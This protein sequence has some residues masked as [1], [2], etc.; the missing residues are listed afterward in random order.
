MTQV[1]LSS[2]PGVSSL[3]YSGLPRPGPAKVRYLSRE[4]GRNHKAGTLGPYGEGKGGG[5]PFTRLVS[6]SLCFVFLLLNKTE[7]HA[8]IH[9]ASLPPPS[10]LSLFALQPLDRDHPV[11]QLGQTLTIRTDSKNG[12]W[13]TGW[14][15]ALLLLEQSAMMLKVRYSQTTVQ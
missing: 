7:A 10:S 15:V 2:G 8:I 11:S 13:V 5:S 6:V 12:E 14:Q 3:N 1:R 9:I 4:F